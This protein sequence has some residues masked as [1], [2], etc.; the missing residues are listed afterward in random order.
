[1]KNYKKHNNIILGLIRGSDLTK[2]EFLQYQSQVVKV[3][4]YCYR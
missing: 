4:N 3:Y 2:I 1:M